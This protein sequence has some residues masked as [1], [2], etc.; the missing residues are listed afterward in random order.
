MADE[1]NTL[2]GRT[3]PR[4]YVVERQAHDYAPA[5]VYGDLVFM[6]TQRLAPDAPNDPND[7]NVRILYQLKREL[8]E[9]VPGLD[10]VVPT[11][12]PQKLLLV[13]M[14]LS[15]HGRAHR[16]LGWDARSQRY[17]QYTLVA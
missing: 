3:R 15:G 10:F 2:A 9:Y 12:A 11:G 5:E 4:V 13:G 6:D 1:E 17:L 16:V 7:Y 8:N 14:A